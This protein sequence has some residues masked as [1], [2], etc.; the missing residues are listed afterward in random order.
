M[1]L[2]LDHPVPLDQDGALLQTREDLLI[3]HL[4]VG[5]H[6]L[7]DSREGHDMG[8][9]K[10]GVD[11]TLHRVVEDSRERQLG[12]LPHRCGVITSEWLEN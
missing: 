7:F 4:A 1:L 8:G 6:D 9:E 2:G 3:R 10:D 11:P 5:V 12:P